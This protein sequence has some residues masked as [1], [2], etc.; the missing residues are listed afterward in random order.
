[1]ICDL[2][3]RSFYQRE[4]L[5]QPIAPKFFSKFS[6]IGSKV[7]PTVGAKAHYGVTSR[8][9][10]ASVT[11]QFHQ[12]QHRVRFVQRNP[13][14]RTHSSRTPIFTFRVVKLQPFKIVFPTIGVPAHT[15]PT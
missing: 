14:Q 12:P 7:T 5:K 11:Q 2:H 1:M 4:T 3:I 8:I 13:F 9:S 10:M 15:P 6:K